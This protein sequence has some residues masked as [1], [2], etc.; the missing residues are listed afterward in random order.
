MEEKY[1]EALEEVLYNLRQI[2]MSNE[3]DGYIDDSIKIITDV[4][5]EGSV[6][7]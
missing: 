3:S 2:E 6:E 5:K 1:K 4:L 7:R